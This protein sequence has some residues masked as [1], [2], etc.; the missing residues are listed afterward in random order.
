MKYIEVGLI[1]IG[2]FFISW[3]AYQWWESSSSV[4]AIPVADKSESSPSDTSHASSVN[5]TK[6]ETL[7][8]KEH[9]PSYPTS[10]LDYDTK[11]GKDI[12][13]LSIPSIGQ[14]FSVYWGTSEK[15]LQKGVGMYD[16]KWTSVPNRHTGHTVLSGHRDTTFYKLGEIEMGDVIDVSYQGSSISYK[17]QDIW[18]TDADDLSV[19]VDKETSTLTLT[20]C[21]P[22][23]FIGDAPKRYIVQAEAIQ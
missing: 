20:T 14:Q 3:N 11:D 1:L 18:K 5:S 2:I 15:V 12:A 22:F 19:I 9:T 17:V 21:Y 13:T 16:S 8:K 7:N 4:T 6:K 23:Q 10:T